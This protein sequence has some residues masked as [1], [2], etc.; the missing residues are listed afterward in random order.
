MLVTDAEASAM[1]WLSI[2]Y[3]LM[4]LGAGCNHAVAQ[5]FESD[6][7]RRSQM[8]RQTPRCWVGGGEE[9][10]NADGA[11]RKAPP[12]PER[13]ENANVRRT[14]VVL[15][16]CVDVSGKVARTIVV[17]SSGNTEVDAFYRAAVA[18]W[19]FKPA[20][21][22]GVAVPSVFTMAVNWNPR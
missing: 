7:Q 1:T 14:A 2:L 20:T 5:G 19:T 21:R 12:L 16:L 11:A 22:D 15:K 13:F 9:T 17:T 8:N 4:L 3:S 10:K 18:G 6:T